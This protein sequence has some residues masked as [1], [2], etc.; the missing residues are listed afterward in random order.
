MDK[1]QAQ[2][3]FWSRFGWPAINELSEVDDKDIGY[4]YITYEAVD[5]DL[6]TPIL[7]NVSLWDRSTSWKDISEKSDEISNYIGRGGVVVPVNNG[8]MWVKKPSGT[9]FAQPMTT[10]YDDM[11]IKRIRLAVEIEFIT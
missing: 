6:D 8:A 3:S 9:P 7:T 2:Y 10:G 4:R 11:Q 1:W 5:G